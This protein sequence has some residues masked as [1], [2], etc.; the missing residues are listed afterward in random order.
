MSNSLQKLLL[1][2]KVAKFIASGFLGKTSLGVCE[3]ALNL[4]T[5]SLS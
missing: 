1:W 2:V 3:K 5:K 4:V